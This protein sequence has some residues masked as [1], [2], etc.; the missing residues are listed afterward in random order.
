MPPPE[1][2]NVALFPGFNDIPESSTSP[3]SPPPDNDIYFLAQIKD[4]MTITKPTLVLHDR[5]SSPFALVFDGYDREDG[6]RLLKSKGLKKGAT[7][8]VKNARRVP[9]K[10]ESKR[11][12]VRVEK[13]KEGD[14]VAIPG[15]LDTVLKVGGKLLRGDYQDNGRCVNCGSE[16]KWES[17]SKCTGCGMVRYCSKECQGRG[18]NEGGHKAECKVI[19]AINGIWG[20]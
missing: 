18:W 15:P 3:S 19:K 13:G 14:V 12:F 6:I 5:H 11:G 2:S 9:P 20:R 10:D 16:G 7:A 4:D 8:V 17:L 1:F